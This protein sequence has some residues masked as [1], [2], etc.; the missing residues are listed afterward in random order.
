MTRGNQRELDRLK[1]L[2]KQQGDK[3]GIVLPD[4]MTLQ[5]KKEL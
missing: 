5:Q 2:K 4:G 3:K 1:T